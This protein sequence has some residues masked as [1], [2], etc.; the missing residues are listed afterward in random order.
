MREVINQL[1]NFKTRKYDKK[2]EE[3][4]IK[5]IDSQIEKNR[6]KEKLANKLWEIKTIFL[7]QNSYL[8]FIDFLRK[9]EYY[10]AW[11]SLEHCELKI[12]ELNRHCSEKT[13]NK[14][15]FHFI[16]F[17]IKRWQA[18][19]PYKLFSS[20]QFIHKKVTCSICKE[21]ISPRGSCTHII[22]D[23][24]SGEICYHKVEDFEIIGFAIVKNPVMK[25]NV[26][27]PEGENNNFSGLDM[28]INTLDMPFQY[29]DINYTK[30]FIPH[31]HITSSA[32]GLCPCDSGL[33]Y[34]MCCQG[35]KGC[36]IPHL[37]IIPYN[38]DIK[39]KLDTHLS[40]ELKIS[41]YLYQKKYS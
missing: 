3:F 39:N 38:Q 16:K 32:S 17:Q 14:Y 22:G 13:K 26:V 36:L 6:K 33:S 8:I 11:C 15:F 1:I 30:K 34:L 40:I 2:L 20:P 31:E 28:V 4:L 23:L 41:D 35:R 7:A 9:K 29:W 19:Y 5:E 37:Q 27:N 25:S 18:I 21:I 10:D 24:Y 12:N